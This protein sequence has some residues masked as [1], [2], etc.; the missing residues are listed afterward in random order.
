MTYAEAIEGITITGGEPLD[1][2]MGLSKLL[3]MIKKGSNLSVIL[4]SGYTLERIEQSPFASEVLGNIDVLVAGPYAH[5]AP[6]AEG[7]R[8]SANQIVYLSTDRYSLE[9][10]KQTP[11]AEVFIDEHGETHISGVDPPDLSLLKGPDP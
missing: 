7:L 3:T 5:K 9:E 1:Q 4:F 8:G 2:P 10:L 6:A 11:S